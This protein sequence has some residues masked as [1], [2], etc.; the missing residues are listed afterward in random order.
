MKKIKWTG[1][2]RELPTMGIIC[3]GDTRLMPDAMADSLIKQGMAKEVKEKAT[4][5]RTASQTG[6]NKPIGGNDNG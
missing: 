6:K 3:P 2:E 4:T 1:G 5:A